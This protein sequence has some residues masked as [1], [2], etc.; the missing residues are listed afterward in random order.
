MASDLFISCRGVGEKE[1]LVRSLRRVVD[2][3]LFYGPEEV[4]ALLASGP[5]ADLVDRQRASG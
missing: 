4:D 5:L 1:A 3:I 2:L